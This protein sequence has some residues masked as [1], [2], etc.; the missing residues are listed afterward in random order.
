MHACA[1][2]CTTFASALAA[3]EAVKQ[4]FDAAEDVGWTD[5]VWY[6]SKLRADHDDADEK[7]KY[8]LWQQSVKSEGQE[9]RSANSD[10]RIYEYVKHGA[11]KGP[12]SS[13]ELTSRSDHTARTTRREACGLS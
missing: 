5:R 4:K 9:A 10:F 6:T 3:D 13:A 7:A 1:Q 2:E 12:R 11:P 8:A